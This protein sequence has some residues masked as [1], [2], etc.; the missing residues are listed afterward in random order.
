LG[1]LKGKDHLG[2]KDID[3]RIILQ[4]VVGRI[5]HLLSSDRI[6]TT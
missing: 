6:Q 3:K 4:E 5:N 2:D 1:D